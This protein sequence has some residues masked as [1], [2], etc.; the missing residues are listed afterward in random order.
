MSHST[1]DSIPVAVVGRERT[2]IASVLCLCSPTIVEFNSPLFNKRGLEWQF[3]LRKTQSVPTCIEI[4][5]KGRG[6]WRQGTNTTKTSFVL[7]SQWRCRDHNLRRATIDVTVGLKYSGSENDGPWS[8]N[9]DPWNE[10]HWHD[11]D[12]MWDDPPKPTNITLDPNS[13]AEYEVGRWS[14]SD[15]EKVVALSFT[16]TILETPL[17]KGSHVS[18]F[19]S[20]V[21]AH[22]INSRSTSSALA[23]TPSNLGPSMARAAMLILAQSLNTGA[24]FN[25]KFVACSRRRNSNRPGVIQLV[26]AQT[27][28]LEAVSRNLALDSIAIREDGLF[29]GAGDHPGE[30]M[31]EIMDDYEYESDSDLD[32][33]EDN[34][35]AS[36]EE[37]GTSSVSDEKRSDLEDSEIYAQT[38]LHDQQSHGVAAIPTEFEPPTNITSIVYVKGTAYKT[39]RAFIH[40]CYTGHIGFLPLKSSEAV[41]KR[42][43][44]DEEDLRCSPKSM[45]RLAHRLD[46][47]SLKATALAA[48]EENLSKT[49]VLGELFSKFTSQYPVIQAAETKVLLENRTEPEVLEALPN[50]TR[51]II[52]GQMTHADVVLSDVM[53]QVFKD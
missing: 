52:Q 3:F 18:L 4:S 24:F 36:V 25:M 39:W 35:N 10:D 44:Q 22:P 34:D 51:K 40:Y 33:G 42:P 13:P 26:Y 47:H 12:N 32:E 19:R 11:G 50:I 46:I 38:D 14:D 2:T 53:Q 31:M 49:N 43:T 45:Y 15:L 21:S 6:K 17:K 20:T 29:W 27:T 8:E 16:V 23:M 41:S 1:T 9:D 7:S 28:V 30:R 48:I 5:R 37:Q